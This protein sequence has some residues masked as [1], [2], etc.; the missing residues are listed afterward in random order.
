MLVKC[1]DAHGHVYQP[2][3]CLILYGKDVEKD[4]KENKS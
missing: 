1:T 3:C 2:C 4:K